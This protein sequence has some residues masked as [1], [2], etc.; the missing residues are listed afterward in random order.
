MVETKERLKSESTPQESGSQKTEELVFSGLSTQIDRLAISSDSVEVF[1]NQLFDLLVS[2]YRPLAAV[3][4]AEFGG[5]SV[6]DEFFS[7]DLAHNPEAIRVVLDTFLDDVESESGSVARDVT[8][9]RSCTLVSIPLFVDSTE[10]EHGMIGFVFDRMEAGLLRI[11]IAELFASVATAQVVR[12]QGPLPAKQTESQNEAPNRTLDAICRSA[13]YESTRE[14]AYVFVNQLCDR[15][16]CEQIGF[17]IA[18]VNRVE[19]LAVSGIATF[20]SSSPGIMDLRQAMEECFD[21]GETIVAQQEGEA[22]VEREFAIHRRWA[23]ATRSVT[24]S[25]PL[26][27]NDKKIGVVSLRRSKRKPFR[28]AEIDQIKELVA[29]FGPAVNLMRKSERPLRKHLLDSSRAAFKSIAN[30]KSKTSRVVVGAVALLTLWF[31]LGWVSYQPSCVCTVTP[32]NLT[33]V[34]TP[35]DMKLSAAFVRSG[36]RV[37]KGQLLAQFDTRELDLQKL[38]LQ[39]E[40][41]K[42]QVEVR[43][44]ISSGDVP[45]AALA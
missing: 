8:T 39:A 23:D 12:P 42:A 38:Q 24:C 20:K 5:P 21:F 45:N 25:I 28:Q 9:D 17:G 3:I 43:D 22:C 6:S 18:D 41:E 13:K 29:P 7:P 32:A 26:T 16:D 2:Q 31:C 40:I 1:Y 19:V 14:L 27:V 37:Q 10:G 15:F 33:H 4:Q 35:F 44:A 11:V 34:L 36:D 30:P